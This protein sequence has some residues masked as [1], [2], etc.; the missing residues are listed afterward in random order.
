M[1]M[2]MKTLSTPPRRVSRPIGSGCGLWAL[3]LF[4]LPHTLVGF[5]LLLTV[6]SRI[7]VAAAG[8][9]VNGIVDEV[10]HGV[11]SKGRPYTTVHYHYEFNGSI[12]KE[13]YSPDNDDSDIPRWSDA[14]HG[15]A[16]GVGSRVLFLPDKSHPVRQTIMF[17]VAAI[18]WNGLMSIFLYA[19]WYVPLRETWIAKFGTATEGT[20][21]S[22]R[23]RKGK[24][25]TYHVGYEFKSSTGE[26]INGEQTTTRVLHDS[27]TEGQP[28]T[29]LYLPDKPKRS[30]AVEYCSLKVE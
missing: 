23:I 28:V 1:S 14:V 15:K 29:V 27:A 3:R 7:L 24:S 6:P 4:L 26:T 17:A 11:S 9:D 13:T 16:M 10:T 25:N 30:L 20:I 12:H 21:R 18:F 2:L 19:S 8:S 22:K 5:G